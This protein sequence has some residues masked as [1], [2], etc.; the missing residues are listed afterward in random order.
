[1]EISLWRMTPPGQTVSFCSLFCSVEADWETETGAH[2]G[3]PSNE[4]RWIHLHVHFYFTLVALTY[5]E[6]WVKRLQIKTHRQRHT[7][8]LWRRR[9]WRMNGYS[10]RMN[11][12][13]KS[14]GQ[15]ERQNTRKNWNRQPHTM[16]KADVVGRLQTFM[17]QS[18]V[19]FGLWRSQSFA[20]VTQ[21][22]VMQWIGAKETLSRGSGEAKAKISFPFQTRILQ[23][24]T[25]DTLS[26][27]NGI[28]NA[29]SA[30]KIKC[31]NYIEKMKPANLWGCRFCVRHSARRY[32]TRSRNSQKRS[33]QMELPRL[34]NRNKFWYT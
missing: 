3:T 13:W 22:H 2:N 4:L 7:S 1:M 16:V 25:T 34:S 11:S 30:L 15:A 26:L 19:S 21:T 14:F 28:I 9:V 32:L 18:H 20:R 8:S 29:V 27:W 33:E 17:Q 31:N 6:C 23:R 5:A 10:Y 24:P 12:D